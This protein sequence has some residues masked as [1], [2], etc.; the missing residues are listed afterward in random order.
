MEVSEFR[1]RR[2]RIWNR[3]T[4]IMEI[5]ELA[6]LLNMSGDATSVLTKEDATAEQIKAA[7]DTWR[8]HQKLIIQQDYAA[9][10][11]ADISEEMMIAISN[12]AIRELRKDFSFTEDEVKGK[13][14][15]DVV[16]MASA[17]VKDLVKDAKKETD[18]SLTEKADKLERL[19]AESKE[20]IKIRDNKIKEESTRVEREIRQFKVGNYLVRQ[21]GKLNWDDKDKADLYTEALNARMSK[22]VIDPET[23]AMKNEDGTSVQNP[24]GSGLWETADKAIE[25]F[26]T[27]HKM[28]AQSAV[29]TGGQYEV[30]GTGDGKAKYV[31][32]GQSLAS[33]LAVK[34]PG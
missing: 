19:L 1:Y 21:Y 9:K 2:K 12:P 23:G 30:S 32:V 24:D 18:A 4:F 20:E 10:M 27:K 3:K 17:K 26:A 16:A 8:D 22:Y 28:T 13:S 34:M 6:K 14:V 25:Y 5:N 11:K 33:K 31:P 15:K 29:G 7:V